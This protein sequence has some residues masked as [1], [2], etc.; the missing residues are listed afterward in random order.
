MRSAVRKAIA[1][2]AK[3]L[4]NTLIVGSEDCALFSP[5]FHQVVDR[6]GGCTRTRTLDPLIKSQ[7]LYQLSYAPHQARPRE[8]G[9]RAI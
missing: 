6:I 2:I 4:K 1:W 3:T 8:I 7:L 9:R 5:H